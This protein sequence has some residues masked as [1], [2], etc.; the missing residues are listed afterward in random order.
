MAAILLSP[1]V[2][3]AQGNLTNRYKNIS[4]PLLVVTST[5]DDDPYGIS[6][7][8]VRTTIWKYS[9]LG[10]KYLLQLKKPRKIISPTKNTKS[11]KIF[12]EI[13]SFRSS[14]KG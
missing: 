11:T 10:N 6:S 5:E 1:S 14:P 13:P 4:I 9:P 12:K 7:P 3:M 8:F 2:D